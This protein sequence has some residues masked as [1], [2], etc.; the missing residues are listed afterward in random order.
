MTSP[1]IHH[2]SVINRDSRQSFEF[3]HKLL[4]LDFLLKTVNQEDM[5]MYHLFFGDT[6]GRPGTEFSVFELKQGQAKAYGTNTLER[7]VF[8]V[9]SEASL[10]FWEQRLRE[11]GVFNCEIEDYHDTKV[12]RFEDQEGVQLGLQPVDWDASDRYP[13]TAGEIPEEHAIFGIKAVHARV[14]YTKATA[15]S[16]GEIFG[17]ELTD[18]FTDNGHTVSVLTSPGALFGQELHLV[19]D[20]E[21]NLE[22]NGA[23]AIHHIA[24]NAQDDD[25]LLAVEKSIVSKNFHYSG[26][27][28][29][30]FFRSLYYR[31][32][33]D[34]LIEVATEQT[35][36]QK[37]EGG[38]DDFDAIP[39]YLP[40]FLEQRRGF[41]ESKLY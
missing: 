41:I 40:P 37:P 23:G 31:E 18:E 6:T 24:L 33:N 10:T 13:Y 14:R 11:A 29:R 38:E 4:G 32:P 1:L 17:L 19:E 5:E 34:L 16:F 7:T 20:R 30:E 21:R 35:D 9:P 36:F 26:I 39:L 3:Y 22:V 28:N 12:L 8:A 25:A 15:R 2:V 27:K